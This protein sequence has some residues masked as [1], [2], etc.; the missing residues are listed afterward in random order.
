MSLRVE[1]L[2]NRV[3][4]IESAPTLR[5]A[6]GFGTRMSGSL[7]HPGMRGLYVSCRW[8]VILFLPIIPL[9]CYIVSGGRGPGRNYRFHGKIAWPDVVESFG[10]RAWWLVVSAWIEGFIV[11]LVVGLLIFSARYI[12]HL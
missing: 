5:T 10:T 6:N 2:L 3:E 11:L 12:V 9:Q 1:D 8:F 7:K 4:P